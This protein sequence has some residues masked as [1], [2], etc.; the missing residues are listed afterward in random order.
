M[1]KCMILIFFLCFTTFFTESDVL[2]FSIESI[3]DVLV[4]ILKGMSKTGVSECGIFFQ[5][6]KT[7]LLPIIDEIIKKFI[8]GVDFDDILR[9]YGLKIITM[10]GLARNC[11]ILKA[12]P[13]IEKFTS[14]E[15]TKEIGHT[16][17]ITGEAIYDNIQTYKKCSNSEEKNIIIGKIISIIID[18]SFN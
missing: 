11:T 6:K 8:S 1:R 12:L 2:P 10:K 17:N 16:I 13:I 7:K 3:Y 14:V 5:N 18:F 9:E 4:G 15:G